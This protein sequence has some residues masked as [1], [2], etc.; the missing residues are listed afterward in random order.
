MTGRTPEPAA[1]E[2]D[3]ESARSRTRVRLL[4][5][6]GVCVAIYLAAYMT[7][8]PGLFENRAPVHTRW[9]W[10][11]SVDAGITGS[12]THGAANALLHFL[13][14]PINRVDAWAFGAP[15]STGHAP[16]TRL[17]PR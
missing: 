15:P 5:A 17:S 1:E 2:V 11:L 10:Y 7:L 12:A 14:F 3:P 8:R 4:A 9:S 16:Q 6:L 13:F